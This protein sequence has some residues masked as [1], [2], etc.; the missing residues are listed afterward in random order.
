[1]EIEIKLSQE[2]I[3][4]IAAFSARAAW[5]ESAAAV[6]IASGLVAV[7]GGIVSH[8]F[9][10]RS[11]S[12][13]RDAEK[14]RMQQEHENRKVEKMHEM[15]VEALKALALINENLL[16]TVWPNPDY[17]SYEAYSEV[18]CKMSELLNSL[19]KYLKQWSYVLPE[20]IIRQLRDVIYHCNQEHWGA[21][22]A[23]DGIN[24]EPT[25][26]E[27]EAAEEIVDNL[28]KAISDLKQLLGLEIHNN[29]LNSGA[30]K[31][32]TG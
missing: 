30:G 17:D 25:E 15:Q 31:A 16:P 3:E 21:T 20:N 18:V 24:Y 6:A 7:I 5:Y 1:M 11:E 2:L 13:R 27:R 8:F 19:D 22:T 29:A 26:R 9:N 23:D 4:A 12:E 14:Q 28:E 32:D 10:Q